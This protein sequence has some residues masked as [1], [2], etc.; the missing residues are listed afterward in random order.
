MR[1]VVMKALK[2]SICVTACIYILSLSG[3]SSTYEAVRV[4]KD[5]IQP[6]THYSSAAKVFLRNDNILVFP[7]GFTL[8][9]NFLKGKHESF[10]YKGN[11]LNSD[12]LVSL[13]SIIAITQYIETTSGGL[14]FADVLNT[15][16]GASLTTLAIYCLA[17]PK[18]CFGSCPTVYVPIDD[19]F[20]LQAELFSKCISRQLE[21]NDLDQLDY[22]I[23]S[24]GNIKLK[25][26]NEALETH[27]INKFNLISV[28]HP[29]G[30]K[31][32]QT[33]KDSLCLINSLASF[34]QANSSN[35]NPI[36]DLVKYDDGKYFRSDESKILELRK[37]PVKDFVEIKS[38]YPN[39]DKVKMLI[40][41][42]NTLLT[43]TLLYDV[44]IGSQGIN[45]LEWSKK[46]NEDKIYAMQFK[47]VYDMFSG[48][49]IEYF[50]N[51]SWIDLGKFE[52]AG[53]LN[54]KYEVVEIPVNANGEVRV[55][56]NFIPDN[57]M[58]D[59]IA[60]DTTENKN[61]F[62]I[63]KLS[64]TS[65]TDY[66]NSNID[67]LNALIASDDSQYLVTNPGDSY[68][69]NYKI[70]K[71]LDAEVTLFIESK[72]YYYEWIRGNWIRE[73]NT[74]YTFNLFD[75]QGTLSKL[76]D[77][78]IENKEILEEEFFNT[79]IPLKEAK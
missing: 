70:S 26:T 60:F 72:G 47:T 53:P 50:H 38:N 30:T 46:M 7:D 77:S 76:V 32:F 37:A 63:E 21:A 14:Y 62:T 58:I 13:D 36:N 18:C 48:I 41:Y 51:N 75:V 3:C 28:K 45:A 73:R 9:N 22:K 35:G 67:Y 25:I 71:P 11:K 57:I 44:V 5:T 10:D 74:N 64:P 31:V 17:C 27:Y 15:L 55:K 20:V 24:D 69:L 34:L 43:T 40:K 49:S 19:E 33:N 2:L 6:S 78:W 8:Q 66:K 65:I 16:F 61:N 39:K 52:D 4:D 56:L 59:Y 42:R 1:E 29:Y 79:R 54:W 23:P 12:S 68:L